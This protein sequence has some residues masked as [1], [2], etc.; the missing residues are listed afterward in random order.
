MNILAVQQERDRN[1]LDKVREGENRKGNKKSAVGTQVM[2][3]R[4]PQLSIGVYNFRRNSMTM[5]RINLPQKTGESVTLKVKNC[6]HQWA[7]SPSIHW[8]AAMNIFLYNLFWQRNWSGI[9]WIREV[10]QVYIL[11][12]RRPPNRTFLLNGHLKILR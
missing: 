1:E 10:C 2:I 11:A 6:P 7:L 5:T 3:C 4:I 12:S 9:W 8:L